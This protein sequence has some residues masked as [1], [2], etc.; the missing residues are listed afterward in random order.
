MKWEFMVPIVK[1]KV[2]RLLPWF[3][4][5]LV[6]FSECVSSSVFRRLSSVAEVNVEMSRVEQ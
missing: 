5:L 1:G 4:P 3:L 6:S 2:V